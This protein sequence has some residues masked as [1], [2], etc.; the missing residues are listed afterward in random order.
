VDASAFTYMLINAVKEQQ[1]TIEDQE[2]RIKRLEQ[3]RP[4]LASL[5][6]GGLAGPLIG[7][8]AFG[9]FFGRRRRPAP[10]AARLG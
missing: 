1:R 7:L 5:G 6:A 4:V 9:Y 3:G 8:V 10:T 2:A